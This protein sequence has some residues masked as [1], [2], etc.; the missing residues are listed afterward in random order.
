MQWIAQKA[1]AIEESAVPAIAEQIRLVASDLKL[2]MSGLT[3]DLAVEAWT[4]GRD[5]AARA[6]NEVAEWLAKIKTAP[7]T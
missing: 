6:Q 2:D 1:I 3:D 7:T 5:L 4:I